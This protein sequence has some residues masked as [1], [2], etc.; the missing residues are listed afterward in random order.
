MLYVVSTPIG[1]LGDLSVR[2]REVLGEVETVLAE[3]TRVT[4]KLLAHI[5]ATPR[6]ERFDEHTAYAK[7][8]VIVERVLAGE[9]IALVSDAG[10]PGVSDPGQTLIDAVLMAA[11]A[12]AVTTASVPVTVIPGPSALVAALTASG[13]ASD[14]FYFGG[15]LSRKAKAQREALEAL[16]LPDAVFADATLIF[17]ESPHRLV[18]TLETCAAVFG[19]GRRR[20]AVVRELTKLHEEVV[21]GTLPELAATFAARD[22]IKGEIVIIIEAPRRER[23]PRVHLDKYE[24]L[25]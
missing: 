16:A 20:A 10:T 2:A 23:I 6:V 14:T 3:D 7:T 11:K 5:G 24:G 18:R 22:S 9:D 12:E 25:S 8:P 1:N 13:L 15:F 17:Y 21:R 19:A 4:G